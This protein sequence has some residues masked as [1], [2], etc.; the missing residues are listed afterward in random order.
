MNRTTIL[1]VLGLAAA[2]LLAVLPEDAAAGGWHR[3]YARG[4]YAGAYGAPAY[5]CSTCYRGHGHAYPYSGWGYG[6]GYGGWATANPPYY[7]R[8]SLYSA[9]YRPSYSYGLY[10]PVRYEAAYAPYGYSPVS[11]GYDYAPYVAGPTSTINVAPTYTAPYG[12]YGY[13][14]VGCGCN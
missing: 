12:A 7:H 1:A 5:P 4:Y 10:A 6:A 8:G 14:S 13:S 2:A 3:A 11:A 9:G